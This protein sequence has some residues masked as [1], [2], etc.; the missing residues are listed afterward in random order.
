[1][2]VRQ[3]S[4]DRFHNHA[5][6]ALCARARGRG[7]LCCHRSS[8]RCALCGGW[9]STVPGRLVHHVAAW[10][11]DREVRRRARRHRQGQSDRGRILC[12]NTPGVLN[13]SVAEHTLTLILAASRH[14]VAL[15]SGMQ[16]SVW[17]A[18]MGSEIAGKTLAIMGGFHRQGGSAHRGFRVRHAGGGMY[19]NQEYGRRGHAT[20]WFCV[21]DG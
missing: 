8:Q 10:R 7:R 21:F 19:T 5:E 20:H 11:C 2:G 17:T 4:L 16:A 13:E 14:F 3:M 1:M 12:T 9:R 18:K 15:A 6:H